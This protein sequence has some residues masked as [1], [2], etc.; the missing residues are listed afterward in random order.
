MSTAYTFRHGCYYRA[1]LAYVPIGNGLWE[2]RPDGVFFVDGIRCES[3]RGVGVFA[4][5]NLCEVLDDN[6]RNEGV[7]CF[8]SDPPTEAEL[9]LWVRTKEMYRPDERKNDDGIPPF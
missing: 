9:D 2:W 3:T 1:G 6:P 5:R 4:R 7:T 8:L